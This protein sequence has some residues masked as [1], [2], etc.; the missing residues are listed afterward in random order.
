MKLSLIIETIERGGR[1]TID[2]LG[3]SMRGLGRDAKVATGD[4]RGTDRAMKAAERSAGQLERGAYRVGHALGTAARQGITGMRALAARIRITREDIGQLASV[5]GR[6]L[7][8]GFAVA[9][10]A[11]V[12]GITG[13]LYKIISAGMEFEKYRT[14]LTGLM[15]SVAAGNKAMDWV[16]QFARETPYEV[17]QVMEAFIRLKAYGIDPTDG[18]LRTLGDTAGGMGKDLMQAVEMIADAQTGEF[19]R[20]KEFGIKASQKGQEVTF[21]FMRNGKAMTR[22]AKKNGQEITRVLFDI[23]NDRFAGG[24]DRLSQTTEGKWSNVM[25]R[26]TISAKRVWEGGFGASVNKQLDRFSAWVDGMEKDGSL[27]KWSEQTGK[28]LGDLVAKA[29]SFDWDGLGK[30]IH[31]MAGA[32]N[33]LAGALRGLGSASKFID[34]ATNWWGLKQKLFGS[35]PEQWFVPPKMRGA[36]PA[37]VP[38][39]APPARLSP[40]QDFMWGPLVPGAR[41]GAPAAPTGHIKIDV[42]T[43]RGA[44]AHPTKVAATGMSLDLNTGRAMQGAA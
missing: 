39:P 38:R 22:E 43:D 32:V 41:R 2:G 7:G 5:G 4:L 16:T 42:H 29:G 33:D 27:Q 14:Q 28:G 44:T 17:A 25:D 8:T 35:G 10:G 1:R 12:G 37:A 3:K 24:M 9:G 31:T 13:G 11:I 36:P 21:S 20:L 6:L 18:S 23:F 30:D 19:E 26:M 34:D 15:G 40:F